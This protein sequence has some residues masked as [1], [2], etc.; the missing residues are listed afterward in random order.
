MKAWFNHRI[1]DDRI[2]KYDAYVI[3]RR[4]LKVGLP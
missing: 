1:I 3:R 2:E 4:F